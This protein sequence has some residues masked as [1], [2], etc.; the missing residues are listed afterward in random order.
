M[1]ANKKRKYMAKKGP[2]LI[3]LWIQYVTPAPAASQAV[4]ESGSRRGGGAWESQKKVDNIRITGYPKKD[5][6]SLIENLKKSNP[7]QSLHLNLFIERFYSTHFLKAQ[8]LAYPHRE[9]TRNLKTGFSTKP[10]LNL[11]LKRNK[12]K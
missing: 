6:Q 1:M 9:S 10:N 5:L 11:H 8:G 2:G 7:F 4:V 12:D 3:G